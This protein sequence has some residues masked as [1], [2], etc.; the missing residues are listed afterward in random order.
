MQGLFEAVVE[1]L[2]VRQAFQPYG[3]TE[4]NAM[5]LLHDL[6]EPPRAARA[7]GVWPAD[8]IEARVVDPETGRDQPGAARASCGCAGGS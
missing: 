4:V 8:G 7:P 5:S 6:D 3:M 1:R 2:G